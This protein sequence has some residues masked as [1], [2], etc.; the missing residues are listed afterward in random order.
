MEEA[1]IAKIA[2]ESLKPFSI[3]IDALL[4]PRLQRIK[5]WS[6][7]RE[8]SNRLGSTL[9]DVLL[10]QY[11]RHLLRRISGITTIVFPQQVLPLTSI[12][13]PLTLTVKYASSEFL[14][15]EFDIHTLE[16]GHNY[17]IVDSAGMGKSTFAKHLVLEILNSTAKIPIFFE[18]RRIDETDSLLGNLATEFDTTKKD[19]DERLLLMLLEEGNFIR[20]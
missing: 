6:E 8:L 5:N 11:L 15:I 10:D 9:I 7:K 12:Y 16:A 3:V 1:T 14:N 2:T 4:A 13:E 18:L 19:L 17:T 20:L